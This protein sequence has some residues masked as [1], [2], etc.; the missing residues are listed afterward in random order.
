MIGDSGGAA[1]CAKSSV[2][3]VVS[4]NVDL[5]QRRLYISIMSRIILED[6]EK[7]ELHELRRLV[8]HLTFNYL[9]HQW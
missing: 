6:E 2:S 3:E 9:S 8:W 5:R 4:A 1:F 7:Y